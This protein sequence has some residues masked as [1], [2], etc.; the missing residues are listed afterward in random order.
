MTVVQVGQDDRGLID[1]IVALDQ[2]AFPH[3]TSRWSAD[4]I[5][6]MARDPKDCV[7]MDTGGQAFAIG[8]AVLDEAEV[9]TIATDPDAR[10]RGLASRLLAHLEDW[11]GA[12]GT[13]AIFLEVAATNDP[14]RALYL[15]R[16]YRSVGRRSGYYKVGAERVDALVLRL[17]LKG[18]QNH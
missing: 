5:S 3:R 7:I 6:G 14:A 8:R 12:K 18:A 9:L 17:D 1:R 16:G 11:A 10:R 4:E 2:L 15:A 13:A